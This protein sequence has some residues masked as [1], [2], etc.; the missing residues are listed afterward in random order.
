MAIYALRKLAFFI[1][2]LLVASLLIFLLIR[3]AGGNVAAVVLGKDASPDAINALAHTY[4]LDR[5]YPI[6]YLDWITKLLTGD[7]GHSFRTNEQVANLIVSRLSI[8][9]PLSVA[10]LLLGILIAVPVGTY[11]ARNAGRTSGAVL[12]L[13]SQVG[14][15]VP[16]FW[17]G[18][19]LS[20]LF[21]VKLGW[22]PTGGWTEWSESVPGAIRSLVLPVISLGLIMAAGLSRY[23]RSA[24]L[25]VMN[26]DYV[27]TARASGM[28]RT[29]AL[30]RVGLR[31]A[32]LPLITILG[33][34][35]ADLIGGTVIIETVFSLPGLSRMILANVAAREVIVVQST[36]MLII[37]FVIAVN[38]IVDLLYGLLDP[39]V[40]TTR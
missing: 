7:F 28:T 23:V 18:I 2:A 37:I 27:R 21:G 12:A 40:R 36:V 34:Q 5:P 3:A 17:A 16:A 31:N 1:G 20:L 35:I 39:R 19:L 33:L 26:Q 11:A 32:A 14:I 13:L 25:D 6:Q 8:S 9:I 22:L 38:L 10:G 15:A 24:V 29:E 4:G 30:L